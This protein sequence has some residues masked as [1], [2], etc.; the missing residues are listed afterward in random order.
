M[1]HHSLRARA[2][3]YEMQVLAKTLE[4]ALNGAPGEVTGRPKRGFTLFVFPFDDPKAEAL[5]I[6]NANRQELLISVLSFLHT[7]PKDAMAAAFARFEQLMAEAVIEELIAPPGESP[8]PPQ[9]GVP[10]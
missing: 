8:E 10:E 2:A 6:S 9:D 1:S 3:A 7:Q 5:Y 4:A